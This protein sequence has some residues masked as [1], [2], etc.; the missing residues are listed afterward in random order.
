MG[1][2]ELAAAGRSNLMR[3]PMVIKADTESKICG[4]FSQGVRL[5][6]KN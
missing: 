4:A 3:E 2:V 5:W 1:E 6:G